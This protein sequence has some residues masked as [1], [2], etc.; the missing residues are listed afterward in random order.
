MHPEDRDGGIEEML[1][2]TLER[3]IKLAVMVEPGII[4]EGKEEYALEED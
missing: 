3:G 1:E 4:T 2:E